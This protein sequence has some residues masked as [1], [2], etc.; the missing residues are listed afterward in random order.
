MISFDNTEIAFKAKSDADLTRAYRLFKL[1]GNPGLVKFG[2]W[3]TD[4]ALRLRLP[5]RGAVK[6]T[7]FKQFCGGETIAECDATIAQLGKFG[8]GT[9]W[10]IR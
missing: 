2:K 3:A 6:K 8:I 1:V 7:I 4:L 5:I 10:I 9:I